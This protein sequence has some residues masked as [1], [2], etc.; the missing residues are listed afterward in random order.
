M[1]GGVEE[2]REQEERQTQRERALKDDGWWMEVDEVDEREEKEKKEGR[3]EVRMTA[4]EGLASRGF[5]KWKCCL[6]ANWRVQE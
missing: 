2:W 1:R 3:K 4:V 5:P 6:A